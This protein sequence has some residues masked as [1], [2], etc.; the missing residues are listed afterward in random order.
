MATILLVED[1]ATLVQTIAYTL[2]REGYTVVT[3]GDGQTALTLA[4]E[5]R[6][7]VVVL[8][9]M[10]PGLDGFEVCRRLRAESAVPILILSARDTEIDRVVG[11]EIG[12]DD[13]LTKPFSLRELLA[14]IRAL[15]RRVRML[16]EIPAAETPPLRVGDLTIDPAG[17][18]VWRNDQELQ[19]KPREFDL[20]LFLA[21]H[22]GQVFSREQL[23]DRVWGYE[24]AVDSRTV[25]VHVRW[26]RAKIEDDP[27]TPRR[28]QTVRG[29]GYR[30]VG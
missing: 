14:R 19:L 18:R 29:V 22:R 23:L 15:L 30:L 4:R 10:L 13:Y 2:R 17:R 20:L 3:A 9:L 8:D 24:H 12:A 28:L 6:P 11:L 16:A 25:D 7:D 21:R 27:R 26:L 5:A 1:E